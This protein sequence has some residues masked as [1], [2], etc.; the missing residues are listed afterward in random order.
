LNLYRK[1]IL[2]VLI[3]FF[4][5]IPEFIFGQNEILKNTER[6][7]VSDTTGKVVINVCVDSLGNVISANFNNQLSTITNKKLIEVSIKNAKKWK[8]EP[9]KLEIQ[10]GKVNYD[11]GVNNQERKGRKPNL[12]I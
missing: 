11:F 1:T 4:A 6:E 2:I 12:R 10:C 5:I 7:A 3:T 9:S 8:F